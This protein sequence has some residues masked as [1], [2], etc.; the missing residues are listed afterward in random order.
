MKKHIE[1]IERDYI[2]II[3]LMNDLKE[4]DFYIKDFE[5]EIKEWIK[6]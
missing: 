5:K 1:V 2:N 6:Y 3:D 4:I